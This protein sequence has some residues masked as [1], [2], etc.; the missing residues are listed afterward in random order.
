[1]TSGAVTQ[2]TGGARDR[3]AGYRG[4]RAKAEIA[5]KEAESSEKSIVVCSIRVGVAKEP[6]GSYIQLNGKRGEAQ[7]KEVEKQSKT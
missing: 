5:S 2:L 6:E 1:M 4:G 7:Q 3:I